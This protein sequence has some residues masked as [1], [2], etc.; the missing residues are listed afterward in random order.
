MKYRF[1]KIIKYILA[2]IRINRLSDKIRY[3][4]REFEFE[5]IGKKMFQVETIRYYNKI[6]KSY[7]RIRKINKWK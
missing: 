3:D 7:A 5:S 2:P 6:F 1:R 4:I